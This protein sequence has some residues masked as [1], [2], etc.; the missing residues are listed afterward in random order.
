MPFVIILLYLASLY[1][2]LYV[3]SFSS[4]SGIYILYGK[5]H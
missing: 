5:Q 3:L 2:I 1:G 4:S